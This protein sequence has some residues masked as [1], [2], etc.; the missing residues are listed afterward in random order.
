MDVYKVATTRKELRLLR[1]D[2]EIVA[3]DLLTGK[4]VRKAGK[5]QVPLWFTQRYLVPGAEIPDLKGR[6]VAFARPHV[7]RNRGCMVSELQVSLEYD[8]IVTP[9]MGSTIEG[10]I[11]SAEFFS[12]YCDAS[13]EGWTGGVVRAVLGDKEVRLGKLSSGLKFYRDSKYQQNIKKF[14]KWLKKK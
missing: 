10:I 11:E 12:A 13:R 14:E 1:G 8:S 9:V 4:V 2:I 5:R 6:S 3:Y 7:S